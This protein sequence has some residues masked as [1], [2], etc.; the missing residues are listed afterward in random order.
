MHRTQIS[1]KKIATLSH[2]E[3]ENTRASERTREIERERAIVAEE[4]ATLRESDT[5][6]IFAG[7]CDAKKRT[8]S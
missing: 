7:E 4:M 2:R 1:A 8:S 3:K 6:E 5:W